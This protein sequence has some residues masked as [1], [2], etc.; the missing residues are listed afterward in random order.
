MAEAATQARAASGFDGQAAPAAD[1]WQHA[2]A[3]G[4]LLAVCAALYAASYQRW[5]HPVID[6]GRDL[7]LPSQLLEG[8]VLY[9]DVLYNYGP[10]VPYLLA[11]VVAVA[12]DRLAVFESVGLAIGLATLAGLYC[13]GLRLH[14][15]GTAFATALGFALLCF[16]ANTT[17]GCNFVLPHAYAATL[18][19]C[20]AVLAFALLLR[21]LARGGERCLALGAALAALALATKLEAG[22]AILGVYAVAAWAHR[23]AWRPLAAVAAGALLCGGLAAFAFRAQEPG[24]HALLAENLAKFGGSA[25]LD[26]FFLRVAGLDQ[27]LRN[28]GV[29]AA[30]SLGLALLSAAAF[31]AGHLLPAWRERRPADLLLAAAGIVGLAAGVPLLADVRLLGVAVPAAAVVAATCARS[32][33]RDPLLLLAA[34]VL[35]SAPRILLHY[36]PLWYGYTLSVPALP[37]A[38][39]ALGVRLPRLTPAPRLTL[40]AFVALAALATAR[41]EAESLARYRAMTRVLDTPKG[42]LRDLPGGRAIAIER[43]LAHVDALPEGAARSLVVLPEGATL[44]YFTGLRNPT[45]YHLFIPPELPGPE[46]EERVLV[47]LRR[48]PPDLVALVPRDLSEFGSSGFGR[49]YG[50]RIARWI[51]RRYR[52][53]GVFGEPEGRW[54][55]QL[56]RLRGA[57][58]PGPDADAARR[59]AAAAPAR[60][61]GSRP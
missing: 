8:R 49:D 23:L 53:V 60:H 4:V 57:E 61:G 43:F 21:H 48:E 18:G 1:R 34:F 26:P 9:R 56:W 41:F 40:A 33:P 27:P 29:L 30:Q 55:L 37:F 2:L 7:L 22:V 59:G 28:L 51:E 14:G 47:E 19:I 58:R 52:R 39:Y 32:S 13:V 44:N 3:W 16:F 15:V 24:H 6:I 35:F 31:A 50:L 45:A 5:G 17:W 38:V 11:A 25:L 12:G 54:P 42:R 20:L 10:V 46:V 36:A